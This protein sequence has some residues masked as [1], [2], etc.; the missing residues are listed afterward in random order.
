M[1]HTVAFAPVR[2]LRACTR[3]PDR[4]SPVGSI[5]VL[6]ARPPLR[7]PRRESFGF[8]RGRSLRDRR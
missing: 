6:I 8:Q 2:D 5:A 1:C 7:L 3:A 4:G